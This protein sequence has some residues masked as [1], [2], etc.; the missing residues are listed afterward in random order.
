MKSLQIGTRLIIAFLAIVALTGY[1]GWTSIQKIRTI[2][3][4]YAAMYENN[5]KTLGVIGAI[6][7]SYQKIRC[8]ILYMILFT[9]PKDIEEKW[10]SAQVVRDSTLAMMQAYAKVEMTSESRAILT[11]VQKD[12]ESYFADMDALHYFALSNQDAD[13][14]AFLKSGMSV[15]GQAITAG[16]SNLLTY[17]QKIGD[18]VAFQ[19]KASVQSIVHELVGIIVFSL[20]FAILMGLVITRSITKPVKKCISIAEKVSRGET[21]FEIQIES[22]DEIGILVSSMKRMMESINAMKQD[23]LDLSIAAVEGSLSVRA[24]AQKHQGNFQKI[25]QGVN[26][27]LDSV[28]EPLNDAALYIEAISMGIIPELITDEYKG[29]FNAIKNNLN[30]CILAVNLLVKDTS[31]LAQSAIE[32]RLSTRADASKHQGD[33]QKVVQGVNNTLDSV[34][35][36]LNVAA[37][38]VADISIGVIPSKITEEYHGDFNKI[39]HNLNQCISDI[40]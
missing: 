1:I 18:E 33:F 29:D 4:S 23:V 15:R 9:D 11:Q 8:N 37:Q 13:A 10:G 21:D 31:M 25:V 3:K 27:T 24:D 40:V 19:N 2:D 30:Q 32:G 36:P 7:S 12:F 14:L 35:N 38:Y 34:I 6:G 26:S 17:N 39:K 16:L 20:L 22:K 5:G 28:I